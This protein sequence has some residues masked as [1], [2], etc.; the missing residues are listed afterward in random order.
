MGTP[1]SLVDMAVVRFVLASFEKFL[2]ISQF[3]AIVA[4]RRREGS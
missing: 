3:A 4:G 2:K 1:S